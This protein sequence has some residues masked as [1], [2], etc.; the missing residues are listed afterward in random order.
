MTKLGLCQE[1]KVIY[2]QIIHQYI[3]LL[4]KGKNYIISMVAEK[5]MINSTSIIIKP[6][7]KLGIE[8][9]ILILI[10]VICKNTITHI[11]SMIKNGNISFEIRKEKRVLV[12]P[13]SINI[14]LQSQAVQYCKKKI[15]HENQKGRKPILLLF[16]DDMIAWLEN[17]K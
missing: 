13:P 6:L 9:D 3:F 2:L 1:C 5:N 16:R 12:L 11:I 8:R 17:Y 15:W 7:C 10:K 14:L 4:N